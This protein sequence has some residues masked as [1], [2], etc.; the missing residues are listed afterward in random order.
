MLIQCAGP[1]ETDGSILAVVGVLRGSIDG[2]DCLRGVHEHLA[3]S[4]FGPS[5]QGWSHIVGSPG[6]GIIHNVCAPHGANRPAQAARAHNLVNHATLLESTNGFERST[7]SHLN[8]LRSREEANGLSA[9]LPK[10]APFL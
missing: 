6:H 7:I 9:V 3:W 2:L 8:L 5:V 10:D 1:G 4:K